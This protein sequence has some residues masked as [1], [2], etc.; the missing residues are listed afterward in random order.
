[1]TITMSFTKHKLTKGTVVYKADDDKA[2]ITSVY[3]RKEVFTANKFPDTLDLTVKWE[4][5]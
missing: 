1:M 3:I 4:G 2:C 5:V